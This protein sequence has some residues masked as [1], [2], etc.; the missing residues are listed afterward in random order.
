[1]G[2]NDSLLHHPQVQ[3]YECCDFL[4]WELDQGQKWVAADTLYLAQ[5]AG[6]TEEQSALQPVSVLHSA[7]FHVIGYSR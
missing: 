5:T 2:L 1:M 3:S 6:N 4:S 7:L